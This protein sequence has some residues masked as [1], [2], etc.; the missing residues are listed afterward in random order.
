MLPVSVTTAL[1]AAGLALIATGLRGAPP[2]G[3]SRIVPLLVGVGLLFGA[4]ALDIALGGPFSQADRE[5]AIAIARARDPLMVRF[6]AHATALADKKT[7]AVLMLSL[8]AVLLLLRRREILS[9]LWTG[10]LGSAA[11]VEVMKLVFAR[12]RP[13]NDAYGLESFSFPSGHS[14]GAFAFFVLAFHVLW[15]IGWLQRFPAAVGAILLILLVGFSRLY[16]LVHYP[17]DI[18]A[19]YLVASLWVIVAIAWIEAGVRRRM[20]LQAHRPRATSHHYGLAFAV[21]VAS[22]AVAGYVVAG[23]GGAPLVPGTAP[24]NAIA[25]GR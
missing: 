14:A 13:G 10:I 22:L 6:L 18:V 16:L 12:P 17:T 8:S 19:G 7:I 9:G 20:N 3:A 25:A 23:H 11:S 21:V 4:L 5:S 24:A 2:A 1:W 15:R